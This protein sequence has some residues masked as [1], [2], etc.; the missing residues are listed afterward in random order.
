MAGVGAWR[1]CGGRRHRVGAWWWCG[2]RRRRVEVVRRPALLRGRRGGAATGVAASPRGGG[3]AAE[4]A[5]RRRRRQR[6]R[7]GR[8]GEVETTGDGRRWQG[9]GGAAGA[10]DLD[11]PPMP[12]ELGN[13]EC[14]TPPPTQPLSRSRVNLAMDLGRKIFGL[15]GYGELRISGKKSRIVSDRFRV[16]TDTIATVFEFISEKNYPNPYPILKISEE[17]PTEAIRIRKQ[18]RNSE[19]IRTTFIPTSKIK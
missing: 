1:W 15:L 8:R 18:V 4:T 13:G 5:R 2:G 7:G 19:T 10:Q 12:R 3:V 16:P 6:W 14:R 9:R 11:A 17:N